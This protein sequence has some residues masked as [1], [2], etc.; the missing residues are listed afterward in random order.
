MDIIEGMREKAC[1]KFWAPS[2]SRTRDMRNCF[3]NP[4]LKVQ[5][6]FFFKLCERP[7]ARPF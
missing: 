6:G 1:I 3:E 2:P 4:V 7:T 5:N